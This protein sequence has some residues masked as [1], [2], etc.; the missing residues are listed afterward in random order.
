MGAAALL[1]AL[2][3]DDAATMAAP[4]GDHCLEGHE[5]GRQGVAVVGHSPGVEPVPLE[6]RGPRPASLAPPL[7]GG[8][9][10]VV[11]V[12]EH[13]AGGPGV[14]GRHVD[15]HGGAEAV[16]ADH[17]HL[18]PVEAPTPGP[19]RVELGRPLQLTVGLPFG[20]VGR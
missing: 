20:V 10:V 17:L 12:D 5:G 19:R 14:G 3:Q 16:D 2:G 1:G 7:E 15:E 8:L 9:L 4:G 6:H 13:G 11:A 18:R